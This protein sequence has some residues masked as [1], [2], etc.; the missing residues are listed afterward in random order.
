[1]W[2]T[3]IFSHIQANFRL[4]KYIQILKAIHFPQIS[5]NLPGAPSRQK[6]IF[7]SLFTFKWV[8]LWLFVVPQILVEW[9]F[10]IFLDLW[11]WWNTI[12]IICPFL[13]LL[14]S[15]KFSVPKLLTL[16]SPL[17]TKLK[18]GESGGAEAHIVPILSDPGTGLQFWPK[19]SLL[20][21][22]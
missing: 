11:F 3:L 10:N 14:R 1:M 5:S 17:V 20:H 6:Y 16:C 4:L 21:H 8:W 15:I 7:Q 13:I 12:C 22:I 2:L 9:Y 18:A 19:L